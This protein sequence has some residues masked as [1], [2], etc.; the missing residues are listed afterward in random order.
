VDEL[1]LTVDC[2]LARARFIS[3][4]EE[5]V[6]AEDGFEVEVRVTDCNGGGIDGGN[7]ATGAT[8]GCNCNAAT[9]ATD[10]KMG[11]ML[12]VGIAGNGGK[13]GRGGNGGGITRDDF[14]GTVGVTVFV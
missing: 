11:V 12:A 5:G 4:L 2:A 6:E 13:G 7:A 9:G 3:E 1:L 10:G 8:D 14:A